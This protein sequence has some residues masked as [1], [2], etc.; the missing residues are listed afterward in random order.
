MDIII[1]TAKERDVP[2]IVR[3]T[4][5]LAEYEK[6]S[7]LCV[8]TEEMFG[9]LLF[10]ER[11]LNSLIAEKDGITVGIA[12]YYFYKISTFSGRRV[13]YLED[14]YIVPEARKLGIGRKIFC[15]LKKI[16]K[17]KGCGKIEWKCLNWNKPSLDFYDR[18]GSRR[19]GEWV[20]FCISDNEF[21]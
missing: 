21:E 13:L 6:L 14:L 18:L 15:E 3:L 2:D 12:S 11:S 19:D 1:R 10:E 5:E 16:A 17:E 9:R 8:I 4:R 7:E 20:T